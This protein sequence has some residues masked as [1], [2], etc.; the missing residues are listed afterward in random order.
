MKIAFA[1]LILLQASA[2]TAQQLKVYHTRLPD[3]GYTLYV[4]N[5]ELYPVS[6]RY[7]FSNTGL[8]FSEGGRSQFVA[9]PRTDSFRIG[10]LTPV[11]ANTSWSMAYRYFTA[12]GDVSPAARSRDHVYDLPY[13]KDAAYQIFQGYNG[14]FSHAG[15]NALDFSMPEGTEILAVREGTVVQVVQENDRSC[16]T[17]DCKKYNNYITILHPDGTFAHYAHIRKNGATVKPGDSVKTGDRIAY[18]GNVGW[19]SGPHLHLV[20]FSAGFDR[21]N[22]LPVRFRV[23]E[24][25]PALLREGVTYSRAY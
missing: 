12:M 20:I 23:E 2:A 3:G 17:A 8:R 18:S 19:S 5:P 6:I 15:E 16:A 14:V 10:V 22:T 1:L 13:A 9:P 24:G 4:S 21:W 25:R 11:S 7:E